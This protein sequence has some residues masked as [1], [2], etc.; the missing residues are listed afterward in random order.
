MPEI[1]RWIK[2]LEVESEPGLTNVQ[3]MLTNYD[4][5]PG[6][7]RNTPETYAGE[8]NCQQQSSPNAANGGGTTSSLSGSQTL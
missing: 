3:L 5:R 2:K 6:E 1:K 8:P 4:L 7:H